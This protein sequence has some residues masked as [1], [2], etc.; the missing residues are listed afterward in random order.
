MSKMEILYFIF[1]PQD[2]MESHTAIE[3]S[4][5]EISEIGIALFSNPSNNVY[6]SVIYLQISVFPYNKAQ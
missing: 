4:I 3:Y 1:I 2:M 6:Y 5:C